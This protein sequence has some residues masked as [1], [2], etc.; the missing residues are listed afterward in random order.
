[1]LTIGRFMKKGIQVIVS[2]VVMQICL[3][4]VYAWSIYTPVLRNVYGMT[5][6]QTGSIFGI[7]IAVFAVAMIFAGRFQE[8]YGP[9]V[10]SFIGA[11]F[12]A[13]GYILSSQSNGS[14]LI[15]AAGIGV[16]SGIGIGCGYVCALATAIKWYPKRRG[17]I[18]G[19]AVMGFGGGAILLSRIANGL[20]SNGTDVMQVFLGVGL[21]VG[22]ILIV[23]ALFLKLPPDMIKG[24]D[25]SGSVI[26]KSLRQ[27]RFISLVIG[28]FAGT[29]GGLLVIGNLAPIGISW[30][31]TS[32]QAA[33]AIGLFSIGNMV[34][35]FVWGV[36]YDRIK[37][38]A[39]PL[40]LGLLGIAMLAL[41]LP[42][43]YAGFLTASLFIGFSFGACFVLYA[44]HVATLYGSRAVGNIYPLV[45]L[46]YGVAGI[47]GPSL[48]GFLYDV[49]SS[50]SY[51]TILAVS[52]AWISAGVIIYLHSREKS[53]NNLPA[54]E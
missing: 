41:L 15:L 27:P 17:L 31:F 40:S 25:D 46:A 6:G 23:C 12:F 14:F 49:F 35:R 2:A 48:G 11:L 8:K 47:S 44:A 51:A 45:F 43:P 4:G 32:A 53:E 1:M 26:G 54:D 42:L 36:V 30:N 5:G 9:R 10:V 33:S 24:K 20:M 16:L 50:Y 18:T 38:I 52:I 21:V 37:N 34:G 19:I 29:F 39:I 3:G 22:A 7:T 13:A 28:M